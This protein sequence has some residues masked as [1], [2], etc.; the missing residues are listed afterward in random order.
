MNIFWLDEDLTLCAQYHCDRHLGKMLLESVQVLCTV[1]YKPKFNRLCDSACAY[2]VGDLAGFKPVKDEV[3]NMMNY[4]LDQISIAR[5]YMSKIP[6]K[7]THPNHP[8][9][10]WAGYC[11]GNFKK[12]TLLATKLAN[13][14]EYRKGKPHKSAEALKQILKLTNL[15]AELPLEDHIE[16]RPPMCMPDD[17]VDPSADVVSCYRDYYRSKRDEWASREKPLE[18]KYTRRGVPAWL[19]T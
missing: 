14:Y 1:L 3:G 7:P 19:N 11:T 8:V 16:T 12:L 17:Y 5:M 10:I 4:Y 18:M 9:V 13:E 6:Y 2:A 15:N